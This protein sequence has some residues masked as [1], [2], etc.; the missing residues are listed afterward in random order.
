MSLI[1]S[2]GSNRNPIASLLDANGPYRHF[3]IIVVQV[4]MDERSGSVESISAHSKYAP[5]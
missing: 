5:S 1:D 4:V 2:A 3:T